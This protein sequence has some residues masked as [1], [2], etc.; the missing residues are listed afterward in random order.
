M[1]KKYK[2]FIKESIKNH[3]PL[4]GL[5]GVRINNKNYD[6]NV[7]KIIE[8]AEKNYKVEK[9]K[10]DDIYKISLFKD[11]DNDKILDE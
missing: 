4:E 5:C 11:I 9:I 7:R 10:I 1:I 2:N 6:F 3:K 8:F